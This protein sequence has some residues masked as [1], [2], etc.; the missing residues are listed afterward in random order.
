MNNSPDLLS[1]TGVW[2]SASRKTEPQPGNPV[3]NH[4]DWAAVC[5]TSQDPKASERGDPSKEQIKWNKGLGGQGKEESRLS[6][7]LYL[8]FPHYYYKEDRA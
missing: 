4:T 6:T 8:F 1:H 7:K 2:K 3:P 5:G